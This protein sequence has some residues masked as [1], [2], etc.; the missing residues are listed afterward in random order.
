MTEPFPEP[1]KKT[2]ARPPQRRPQKK[3]KGV[4]TV[5]GASGGTLLLSIAQSLPPQSILAQVLKWASPSVAAITGILTPMVQLQFEHW[6]E[7]FKLW[8]SRRILV[9]MI[10][11]QDTPADVKAEYQQVV[12]QL[13]RRKAQMVLRRANA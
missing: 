4:A 6:A 10:N 1:A 7:D 2:A 13:D 5:G 9:K 11:R 8:R 12:A 3:T